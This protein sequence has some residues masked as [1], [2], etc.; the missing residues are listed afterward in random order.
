MTPEEL[1]AAIPSGGRLDLDVTVLGARTAGRLRPFL[2]VG[3]LSLANAVRTATDDGV[4]LTG[5]GVNGPF[6]GMAV[7]ARFSAGD[8]VTARVT[9]KA[10]SDWSFARAFGALRH[11]VIDSLRFEAP[12]LTLDTSVT[13][14]SPTA[15]GPDESSLVFTGRLLLTGRAALLDLLVPAASHDITGE[16]TMVTGLPGTDLPITPVP[17]VVLLGPAGAT[18]DLGLFTLEKLRYEIFGTP[19]FNYDLLDMDVV[20]A[21]SVT[22]VL[23]VTIG[24]VRKEILVGTDLRGWTDSVLLSA[25]LRG[26]GDA[27][28]S[29]VAA[30][31][32]QPGLQA[33]TGTSL[34][35]P[36]RPTVLTLLV[37]PSA[38]SAVRYVTLKL[39]TDESWPIAGLFTLDALD[40][41]FRVDDPLS[42]PRVS[43]QVLGLFGIGDAGT[44]QISAGYD[45]GITLGGSLR[46]GDPPLSLR[47]VARQFGGVPAEAVPDLRVEKFD[48]FAALPKGDRPL[49]L[50]GLLEMTGDWRITDQVSLT[51][52]HAEIVREKDTRFTA[53]ATFVV[54]RV[55]IVVSAD[56]DPAPEKGWT[57]AGGTGPG[58][59]IPIGRLIEDVGRRFGDLTLPQP[60]AGLTVHDVEV[61]FTTGTKRFFLTA[62]M[63]F[64]IDTVDLELK[65]AIDTYAR[66]LAGRVAVSVPTSAG[67]LNMRLDARFADSAT[68]K[69]FAL[70]Y[71]RAPT[72]AT[73]TIK[74]IVAAI[75]PSAAAY[76]PD[77]VTVD[78][79]RALVAVDAEGGQ[80]V[81][82]FSVDLTLALDLSKLPVIGQH[83]KG[84]QVFGFDPLRLLVSSAP[85]TA[86]QASALEKLL[87]A[88]TGGLPKGPIAAGFSVDGVL[89]LGGLETPMTLP[90]T[91]P[92][93]TPPAAAPVPADPAQTLTG[94][95][96]LWLKVQKSFGPIHVERVGLAY[97]HDPGQPAR[98]ALLL[99]ASISMAG[100]TL[101]A[102]GLGI[103]FAISDPRAAPSFELRGLSLDFKGGPIQISGAFLKSKVVYAGRTYDAYSGK[104]VIRTPILAIGAMGSYAQL[105]EGPSLFV[106]AFANFRIGG[107]PVLQLRGIAAGFGYNRRLIVPPVDK[108]VQFPLVAEAVGDLVPTDSAGELQRLNSYLPPSVGDYFLALG[109]R[110]VICEMLDAFVLVTAAFGHRFELNVLGMTTLVL[111]AEDAADATPV[112]EIQLAIKA[113]FAPDDGYLSLTAVLTENSFLLSRSCHLTGGFAFVTWFRGEHSGDFVVSA[114]GYHPR[115]PVPEQYPVVPR[116]GLN[117]KISDKLS[118]KGGGYF[119]LVPS[120]IMAG[121]SVSINYDD[122]A[123]HAWLDASID[124]LISWQPFRYDAALHLGIGV[125]YTFWLFGSHTISLYLG[126]DVRFWGP[127]FGGTATLDL[128]IIKFT[129]SFGAAEPGPL[130]IPWSRFKKTLLPEKSKIAT[131][132]PLGGSVRP[133]SG[134]DLGVLNPIEFSLVTDV[135]IPSTRARAGG[136]ALPD[137]GTGFGVAPVG[138][139]ADFGSEQTIRITR[140]GVAAEQYFTFVPLRK[141]LPAA[142]WGQE[143]KAALERER[144]VKDLLTGFTV[145]PAPAHEPQACPTLDRTALQSLTALFTETDAF[146][147]H[148]VQSSAVDET[149]PQARARRI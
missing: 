45:D 30:I 123:L 50:Q 39:E 63:T 76:V 83:F 94:D 95:N 115:F 139:K 57:F 131:I 97:E 70:T 3:V 64:P 56:Y 110:A 138:R 145:L 71:S 10:G 102:D 104:A 21:V 134:T 8:P 2:P 89:R 52:V 92:G 147:W 128:K 7:T 53:R 144:L 107:P 82:L 103:E 35:L 55:G 85:L 87:P 136:R 109:V 33:P 119:A 148:P 15:M 118:M 27:R 68:A 48:L 101:A 73:P 127:D 75:S 41:L 133:G 9:A 46:D 17:F 108:L 60:L 130:P 90:A 69:R 18:R 16:I 116:L 37:T 96:S 113:T 117:W 84:G 59:A 100:L 34:S 28:L 11:S 19:R 122:G 132:S 12:T 91:A 32:G 93:T 143:T 43:T 146:A 44:L 79:R 140:A 25:D 121:A 47:E 88:G 78:L 58:Q 77:S 99:D 20:C 135:Q 36:F 125:N 120:A 14:S 22:G 66:T 124:F 54:S 137:A 81:R 86:D 65:L 98:I 129:I 114:G 72:D 13:T 111:P 31:L 42:S 49:T 80:T 24:G 1:Q 5:T 62:A 6:D 67:P 61:S 51:D 126:V 38:S 142:L 26:L 40:V 29:D 105:D 149:D 74:A 4:T 106:Y 23:P 141:N 112:A